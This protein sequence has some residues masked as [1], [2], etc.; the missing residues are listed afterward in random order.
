MKRYTHWPQLILGL[1]FSWGVI[2]VSIQFLKTLDI[3]FLLLYIACI[4]WT[5]GY[6]TI[7]AYQDKKDDIINN[8]K[9]TA[10]L[11]KSKGPIFVKIFYL[12]FLSIIG[13]LVWKKTYN[14]L[15]LTVIII[16]III[17]YIFLSKWEPES[18]K[19]SNYYF[20]FNNLIGLLCFIYLLIF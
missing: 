4:S 11:F 10:V 1:V 13:L 7:Y 16:F 3:N 20:K 17:M 18:K 6:D 2:L 14:H 5:L 15:S 8:I 9:S 19:S 12:I